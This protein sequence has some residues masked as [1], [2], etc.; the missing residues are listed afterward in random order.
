ML[1][2]NFT[3]AV[4]KKRLR[5]LLSRY[6]VFR[7]LFKLID[8]KTGKAKEK[9]LYSQWISKSDEENIETCYDVVSKEDRGAGYN[10]CTKQDWQVGSVFS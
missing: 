9:G 10:L 8:I 7:K 6:R 1:P 5:R 2:R 3:P 4:Q